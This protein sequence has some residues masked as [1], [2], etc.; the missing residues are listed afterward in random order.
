MSPA[1]TAFAPPSGTRAIL[2]AARQQVP[3]EEVP[4]LQPVGTL[5]SD[6][7]AGA[8]DRLIRSGMDPHALGALLQAEAAR[9]AARV[10]AGTAA[11]CVPSEERS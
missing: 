9:L 1:M 3:A 11:A 10:P 5:A 7:I 4:V 6:L 8:I 2:A